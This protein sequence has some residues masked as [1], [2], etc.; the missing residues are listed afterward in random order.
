M[1]FNEPPSE[2][3]ITWKDT[4]K[5]KWAVKLPNVLKFF[6]Y[7]D[8]EY[9]KDYINQ[10]TNLERFQKTYRGAPCRADWEWMWSEVVDQQGGLTKW[11]QGT[12]Q[13]L[14]CDGTAGYRKHRKSEVR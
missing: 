3:G 6:K 10:E 11:L 8:E 13:D 1:G 4:L 12:M 5:S 9:T 2:L 14:G 7:L